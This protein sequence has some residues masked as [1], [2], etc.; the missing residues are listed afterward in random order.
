MT[1]SEVDIRHRMVPLWM[2][3]SVT[4]TL[5]FKVKHFILMHL[6]KKISQVA[7]VSGRFFS[8]RLAPAVVLLLLKILF[9]LSFRGKTI[10][11]QLLVDLAIIHKYCCR[12]EFR[13]VPSTT[14]SDSSSW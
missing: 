6:R 2:L 9:N 8:A 7:N 13:L 4:L 3:Y 10:L 11:K 14:A 5:I 12:S 1:F